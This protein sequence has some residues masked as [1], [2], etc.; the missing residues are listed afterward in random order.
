MHTLPDKP[1][2]VEGGSGNSAPSEKDVYFFF[3]TRSVVHVSSS[4]GTLSVVNGNDY[5]T[6][7]SQH[8]CILCK[9]A[10]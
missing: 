1:G 7:P 9:L 5:G 8:V 10:G 4:C 6:H 3:T 2:N